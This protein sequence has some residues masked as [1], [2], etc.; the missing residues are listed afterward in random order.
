LQENKHKRSGKLT[1][2]DSCH[3]TARSGCHLRCHACKLSHLGATHT[4]HVTNPREASP[5][6]SECDTWTSH[7][8]MGPP[9]HL[10]RLKNM[11]TPGTDLRTHRTTTQ[12]KHT[13][14]GAH[15]GS[16]DPRIGRTDLGSVDPGLPRG[17]RPLVLEAI[18]GVFHSL[19]RCSGL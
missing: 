13:P 3:V 4:C 14:S 17:T 5:D 16:A 19:C 8:S 10:N 6:E 15:L 12:R 9:E 7:G 1:F 2:Y 11:C 18:P